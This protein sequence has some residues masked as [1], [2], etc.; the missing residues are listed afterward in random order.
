[1]R[2]L[3]LADFNSVAFFSAIGTPTYKLATFLL[4][5]LTPSTGNE[6]TTINSFNFCSRNLSTGPQLAHD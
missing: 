3:Y 2:V 6:Y 1:M 4:Q 5:F